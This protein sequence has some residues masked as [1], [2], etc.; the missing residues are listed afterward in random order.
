MQSNETVVIQFFS[1]ADNNTYTH[2]Y[3]HWVNVAETS[4]HSVLKTHL[5]VIYQTSFSP[6]NSHKS[7]KICNIVSPTTHPS[8]LPFVSALMRGSL[9]QKHGKNL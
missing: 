9:I 3:M 7:A 2:L 6:G 1:C 4:T 5:F 8:L